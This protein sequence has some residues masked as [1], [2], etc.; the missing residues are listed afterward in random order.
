MFTLLEWHSPEGHESLGNVSLRTVSLTLEIGAIC[1]GQTIQRGSG[2]ETH[3][4]E[5]NP[6]EVSDKRFK[7]GRA[8]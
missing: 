5:M 2:K 3:N 8:P 1:V 4:I 7:L 6:A